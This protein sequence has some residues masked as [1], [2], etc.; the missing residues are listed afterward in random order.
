MALSSVCNKHYICFYCNIAQNFKFTFHMRKLYLMLLCILL[1][2]FDGYA[3]LK[4]ITGKVT[5]EQGNA[6]PGASVRVKG[7][8]LGTTTD[9]NGLFTISVS[10]NAK[11]LLISSQGYI[12]EET[13]IGKETSFDVK[14]KT[15]NT[16]LDEVVV[17]GYQ[18]VR[19]RDVASAISKISAE[20]IENRPI[21][22]FAQAMQ[23]RAA[24]VA[25]SAANGV[26]GGSLSVIIRG[27]GSISA[28]STPLYV[29]D[30]IQLNTGT[31]SINTQNNPLNFL[32]PDDIESIEVLK[33]AAAA[34]IYG[35]R[36]GNGVVI[37]TTKKGK[38]GKPKL[39][40]N[41]YWGQSSTLR[42]LEVLN[43]QDWYNVRYEAIAN[44]NPSASA[45]TNRNTVLSN[46][47]LP[48]TTTTG[49]VD[50]L[51]TYD[52]QNE[53]FGKGTIANVELSLNGGSEN[54]SYYLSGSYS[55]QTAFIKPTD[56][57][58]AAML[59]KVSFKLNEKLT[60]DNSLSLST[61]SQ[62]A[63]YSLGSTGFGNPAYAASQ[64]LPI[65]P[66]YNSDGTYFGL[67]GSGQSIVGSFNHNVFA[68]GEYVKY[69]TRTNQFVGSAALTYKIIPDLS[70]RTFVGLDYRLTQD[71]R[72]QDPRVNDAFAVN[73]R[74]SEQS[75]WNTNF[76]STT[77]ANYKHT[78]NKVHNVNAL[79]G[80][81]Y[82]SDANQGFQADAQGFPSYLLEYLS[83]AATPTGVSGGFSKSA[84]FSQFAK[85]GYT[86]LSKYIFNYTV[87]RDGSSRFGTNNQFGIF[88]SAQF[89]WN[90][91]DEVFLRDARFLTDFKLRYSFGQAGNDQIG[92]ASFRPLYGTGRIYG[93]ISAINPTQLGNPD[94]S[95]ETREESN[96]GLDISMFENRLSLTADAYR[97]VNKDILL[98]R[99]LYSTSGFTSI[100]QN[101]GAI[102]NK[103]LELLISGKPLNGQFKWFTSFNI[104]FQKNKVLELYDGLKSLPSDA[105]IQVG[106]PLG[107]SFTSQWAGVNPATGR[108]MWYDANGNITY[109]PATADR[110][111]I[112]SIYPK[113]FGGWNNSI[114]Y[115]N[116]SL[117]AFFQY[118]YGRT[119]VDGQYAQ[120]MRMGGATVNQLKEGYDARWQKPGQLAEAPRP[121]NGLA[122]FNSVSWGSGSR[123]HFKTDYIRL[124]QVT[125]SYNL[126]ASSAKKHLLDGARFYVQGINLW[127]YTEWKG[128]DPEFTGE[129]SGI[130]PQS[131]NITV[132]MQIKF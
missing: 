120:M 37:V 90:V 26:P 69:F 111:F 17:T 126:P 67:P 18:T 85:L 4:A 34:S 70:L 36:A 50:S 14:L 6:L 19:K 73:G 63:P 129:N 115:R 54:I 74:L 84:T 83:S 1:L 62:N 96:L 75:D 119:R 21:P 5:D 108:G 39:T 97:R 99:S 49:K 112:G 7:T 68:V 16:N 32:N 131:K 86:F 66:Y 12:L 33:D 31:G 24:G 110:K 35:A 13:A 30:G 109:N 28:G 78:F 52:W 91:K 127:T 20:D 10:G 117:D 9:D 40:F 92:N 23:G 124:K 98:N 42:T 113:Y 81:E 8:S 130:I 104:A 105:A 51:P 114:E 60:L 106:Q 22:N 15:G 57:Q 64:I 132:G 121:F 38:S 80:L 72:Y 100:T 61:V 55:K 65:N 77:T 3:Q 93:G 128:Y 46:L 122:D 41:T 59:S 48:S 27:V 94:L 82:R 2:I 101:L 53:A 87:R 118:E 44:A 88:Q 29:V 79:L 107:S 58:R 95:W 76:I 25:V 43:T 125:V 56:F 71:H 11:N 89:A 103:G 102:E 116:F 47:G 123:Y 45:T